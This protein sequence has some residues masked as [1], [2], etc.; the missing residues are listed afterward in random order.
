MKNRMKRLTAILIC[1]CT[2]LSLLPAQ[3]IA[4]DTQ[5][6]ATSNTQDWTGYTP[7]STKEELDAV[8]N[9]LAGKYYLTNDIVFTAADFSE[10]GAFYNNGKGWAPIGSGKWTAFNGIFDG[11][12]YAVVGL[13]VL[14]D[15][16][17]GLFGTV[18][19]YVCN[20]TVKD[21]TIKSK[22]YAGGI[23]GYLVEGTIVNCYNGCD[24][25]ASST[26]ANTFPQ[27]GGIV[28][29]IDFW[30]G[31]ITS[32][33]NMGTILG[34]YNAGGIV[35]DASKGEVSSCFNV[36]HVTAEDEYAYA[37][38]IAGTVD[39][40]I[41]DCYNTGSVT[42]YTA[43]GIVGLLNYD[44]T[45]G[46]CYSIGAVVGDNAGSLVGR[47]N[48]RSIIDNSYS[49]SSPSIGYLSGTDNSKLCT[50]D[51]LVDRNT[52]TNWDFDA[53]WR[54]IDGY[55]Y[56]QL[57]SA[58]HIEEEDIVDFAGG[59][60][61]LYNPYKISTPDHLNNVRKHLSASFVLVNNVEFD[62]HSFEKQGEFYND[63]DGWVPIGGEAEPF[64]GH[65]DGA[66]YTISGLYMDASLGSSSDSVNKLQYAGL[67][68]YCS[69]IVENLGMIN[70]DMESSSFYMRSFCGSIAG[71]VS[72]EIRNCYHAGAVNADYGAGGIAGYVV[73]KITNCYNT[74][75]V[76]SVSNAG[77]IAGFVYDTGVVQ[78]SYNTGTVSGAYAGGIS[79]GTTGTVTTSYNLGDIVGGDYAGGIAGEVYSDGYVNNCFNAGHVLAK[80]TDYI[81]WAGGVVGSIGYEGNLST[82]YNVGLIEADG[83]LA[84]QESYRGIFGTK[85]SSVTVYDCYYISG[86]SEPN[87][88]ALEC[89]AAEMKEQSTFVNFDFETIWIMSGNAAYLFPELKG[90]E[91]TRHYT[92]IG[93]V[94]G[95]GSVD[96]LDRLTLSRYLANWDGYTI[97]DINA[98]GVDVNCDGSIDTLDRLILSRHL[99]NWAGYEDIAP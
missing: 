80:S 6:T 47:A 55:P 25:I 44:A 29:E 73:G 41:S 84:S 79:G 1:I 46:S 2:I 64:S 63:G 54:I 50:H 70:N 17:A 99:A 24:I 15:E 89:S 39:T 35:G 14:S 85:H 90:N 27:A 69:G 60:G 36:G 10:G 95:D 28:G 97:D 93:D 32:C 53:V 67:F 74:G 94:N 86:K 71:Y 87:S 61:S 19:G 58:P 38:G 82:C 22:E 34:G 81:A 16:Y 12:G 62:P 7:I 83:S 42:G 5:S 37:G 3:A 23:A 33:G 76:D 77:G 91:M 4:V 78:L 48:S 68:G 92:Q 18:S 11:N 66:G 98:I 30:G 43:G 9:N 26:K 40:A 59:S 31:T 49:I 21:G 56:P 8:R 51:Q 13:S 20:L 88:D 57:R 65:F 72:G 96:T 45:M 75:S 52:F